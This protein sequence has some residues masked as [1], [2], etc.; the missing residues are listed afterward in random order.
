M[1]MSVSARRCSIRPKEL[2]ATVAAMA[3]ATPG[4]A[5]GWAKPEN[6]NKKRPELKVRNR[7]V[8]FICLMVLNQVDALC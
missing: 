3:G 4:A 1:T 8:F 2:A 6:G 7:D 5:L